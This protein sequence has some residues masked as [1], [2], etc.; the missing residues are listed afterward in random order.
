MND[1]LIAL[2]GDYLEPAE[3]ICERRHHRARSIT[4][5]V[6]R[7]IDSVALWNGFSIFE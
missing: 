3:R 1:G 5:I 4:N 2:T 7:A 6:D